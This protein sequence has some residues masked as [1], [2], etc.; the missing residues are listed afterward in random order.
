MK[1]SRIAAL[2]FG[3]ALTFGA[4]A[5][6]AGPAV[7]E[8]SSTSTETH[9]TVPSGASSV[10]ITLAGIGDVT[11][12]VDPTTGAVT[13]VGLVPLDGVVQDS[14][15]VTPTGAHL[16]VTLADGTQQQVEISGHLE[17]GT[18][19]VETEV[20]HGTETETETGN[21]S[22]TEHAPET[23]EVQNPESGDTG[24]HSG[25]GDSSGG[26]G[27]GSTGGGSGH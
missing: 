11:V 1:R 6:L 5:G 21:E 25:G 3:A 19:Q 23:P 8:S 24:T 22:E 10:T 15:V 14:L 26:S 2:A 4:V 27:G 20:E 18:V 12:T 9:T 13:D 7:A 16:V 17:D